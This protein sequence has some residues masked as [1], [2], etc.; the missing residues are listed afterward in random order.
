[1]LVVVILFTIITHIAYKQG[2][3]TRSEAR[4]RQI[5]ILSACMLSVILVIVAASFHISIL[6]VFLVVFLGFFLLIIMIA[7]I[8]YVVFRRKQ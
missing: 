7:A 3:I 6:F 2:R 5:L 4:F 8:A 1:M